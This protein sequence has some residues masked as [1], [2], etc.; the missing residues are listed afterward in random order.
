MEY[1]IKRLY[2]EG[3]APEQISAATKLPRE[4]VNNVIGKLKS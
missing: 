3:L 1:M 4:F 2:A